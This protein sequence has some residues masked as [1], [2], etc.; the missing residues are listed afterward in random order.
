MLLTVSAALL[1]D[2]GNG[3]AQAAEARGQ[4]ARGQEA[5]GQEAVDRSADLKRPAPVFTYP[6]FTTKLPPLASPP[7]TAGHV[8]A[9]SFGPSVPAPDPVPGQ[10]RAEGQDRADRMG[11]AGPATDDA[12]PA[13]TGL[14]AAQRGQDAALP[15]EPSTTASA[16]EP[17]RQPGSADGQHADARKAKLIG[18]GRA[19]WY[20]HKGRTASG[21]IYN[22]DRLTA[23]HH[24]LPFGTLLKVVNK[25]NGRS[26]IVK[27]TDRTNERTKM[28]RNYAIDLSRASAR[29]IGL[30]G[31]GQVAL[32]KV[33]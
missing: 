29:K 19:S 16:A 31:I 12:A 2:L 4:E 24:A 13:R 21:E 14:P 26:V 33:D 17:S 11:D 9:S 20:Q 23:A 15:D 30:D 32:Y 1:P 8:E 5:R 3:M 28:K 10:D 27:I 25:A 22:P 18:S 6:Q 7:D